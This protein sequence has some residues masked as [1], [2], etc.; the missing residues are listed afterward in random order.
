MY[1]MRRHRPGRSLICRVGIGCGLLGLF[2]LAVSEGALLGFK[3]AVPGYTLSFPADHAAHPAY[4]TEWWYYTGHLRTTAGKTYGYQLTFFRR[5]L[6]SRGPS[7]NPSKW[8]ADNIYMAHM[9]VTDKSGQRF[10]Y[11]EK[12]NRAALGL[13]GAS[14]QRYHVWNEDWLA[15]RLGSVHHLTGNIPDF[16][17]NLILTPLKSPVLHGAG[18]DGLSQK[19]EGKGY[20]SHYYSYTRMQTEG[21]LHTKEGVFEVEGISWM[22]HEF[23][24]TQLTQSQIGWDW[25]SVQ[26]G[27]NYELMLYHIRHRDGTIDPYSSGTLVQPDGRSLHL[28]RDD[29]QIQTSHTWQSPV[30]GA[31]YPQG[32]TIRIPKAN[33]TLQLEPVMASQELVTDNST[34]VT[35]WEG[36]VQIRGHMQG[37]TIKGV[38]YVEMTGYA[39]R[40]HL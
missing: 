32:W 35:Y 10:V 30:S 34:R 29:F 20:A 15:E 39:Q 38:G 28:Q 16:R 21:V 8:F 2:I 22:D 33:L 26:L 40:A 17:L 4:Q 1:R 19:G 11:G 3:R 5:R 25:F 31:I 18:Q 27:N 7:L 13:A 23:G 36:S 14:K 12:R 6:D 37:Q 24:S 9:A